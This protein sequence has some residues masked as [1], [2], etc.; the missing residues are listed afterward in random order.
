[1]QNYQKKLIEFPTPSIQFTGLEN[2][3]FIVGLKICRELKNDFRIII[4]DVCN[5]KSLSSIFLKKLSSSENQHTLSLSGKTTSICWNGLSMGWKFFNYNFFLSIFS[6]I[7]CRPISCLTIWVGLCV[8][9]N[10]DTRK[11]LI[12]MLKKYLWTWK[13]CVHM[14]YW[15]LFKR[16]LV[17][18]KMSQWKI[19]SP[20]ETFIN[21]CFRA[22]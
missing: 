14:V 7:E 12:K 22:L 13:I 8:N 15:K 11:I 6:P 4:I 17:E 5:E 10:M 9:I 2:I 18:W 19:I 3:C 20:Q 1:L 21:F 16:M